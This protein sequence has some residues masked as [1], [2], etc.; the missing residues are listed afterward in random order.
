MG[1]FLT[2]VID[3]VVSYFPFFIK[4]CTC[5]VHVMCLKRLI[6]LMGWVSNL[7]LLSL[8][9]HLKLYSHVIMNK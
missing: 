8:T 7:Y 9:F 1:F 2:C 3:K 6:G 4:T 5:N